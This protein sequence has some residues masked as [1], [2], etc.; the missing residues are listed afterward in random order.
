[1]TSDNRQSAIGNRQSAE[2]EKGAQHAPG[3]KPSGARGVPPLDPL[4]RATIKEAL[5]GLV[6]AGHQPAA[7]LA[8][9]ME[10]RRPR[11]VEATR[12][13]RQRLADLIDRLEGILAK[14]EAFKLV[15]MQ[16]NAGIPVEVTLEVLQRV[17]DFQ[18]TN[19]WAF[20]NA[21]MRKDYP[22]YKWGRS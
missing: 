9:A 7:I 17:A 3:R 6:A 13:Q 16:K 10:L 1:M 2:G 14:P 11:V 22:H 4:E 21:L 12:D 19:P 18:P 8:V 15:M 5:D 20:V